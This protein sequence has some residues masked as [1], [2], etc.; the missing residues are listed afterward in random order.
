[1]HSFNSNNW[2]DEVDEF[3]EFGFTVAPGNIVDLE[4][5]IIATR[6]SPTGPGTIGL[7]TSL[8]AFATAIHTFNQGPGDNFVDTIVDL[9]S[10]ASL[11]SGPFSVRLMEIGDTQADGVGDT[12]GV[13][14]FRVAEFLDDPTGAFLDVQFNGVVISVP[15][16]SAFAVW[17]ILAAG[18]CAYWRRLSWL[19]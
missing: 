16:L 7:F 1:M 2:D 13:G 4:N 6:S 17:S 5:L 15:E 9:T 10:L 19:I 8:D 3:I 18:V 11:I 12:S 14:T